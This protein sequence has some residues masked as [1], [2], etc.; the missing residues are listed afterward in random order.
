MAIFRI[1]VT[2][3]WPGSGSPGV[4]VFHLRTT[5]DSGTP[6]NSLII[7]EALDH[8][9][10]LYT[11]TV[12][13]LLVQGMRAD[14]GESIVDVATQEGRDETVRSITNAGATDKAP[15]AL[16]VVAGWRTTLAA[17]RGRGRTFF[18]PLAYNVLQTDGTVHDTILTNL[19]TNL[20]TFV[21]NSQGIAGG[22]FVVWG[23]E[24]AGIPEP[25]VGRDITSVRVRDQLAV[26]RSRRD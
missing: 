5:E 2:L 6:G 7:D 4:N 18:G 17:R 9:E 14:I 19:R 21:T 3:T 1:P 12:N 15:P 10:T 23:Q 22:A 20:E 11:W 26:L 13:N 24:S 16:A 25:K 8:L